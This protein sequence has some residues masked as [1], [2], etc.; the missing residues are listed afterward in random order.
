MCLRDFKRKRKC[1]SCESVNDGATRGCGAAR[2]QGQDE[3]ALAEE[4]QE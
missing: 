3:A 2:M 4:D 1:D